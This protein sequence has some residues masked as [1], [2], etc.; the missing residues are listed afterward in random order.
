MK[1][2]LCKDK[3]P[4]D[5]KLLRITKHT[6]TTTITVLCS[7]FRK[8]AAKLMPAIPAPKPT[9]VA[10]LFAVLFFTVFFLF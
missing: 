1:Y 8:I 5:I 7:A 4:S 10:L 2:S 9:A 3:S 6:N